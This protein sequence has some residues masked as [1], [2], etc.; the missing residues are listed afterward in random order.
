MM[1]QTM[2]SRNA[3]NKTEED[4]QQAYHTRSP[5]KG[6]KIRSAQKTKTQPRSYRVHTLTA[7]KT[8]G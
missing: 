3:M 2:V 6:A 5:S 8:L 1:A 4:E 7:G